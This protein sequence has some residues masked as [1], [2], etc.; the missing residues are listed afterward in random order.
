L[1]KRPGNIFC[2]PLAC[3][4]P[5]PVKLRSQCASAKRFLYQTAELLRRSRVSFLA[6]R[7]Y[8]LERERVR[9]RER[10][11]ENVFPSQVLQRWGISVRHMGLVRARVRQ[12]QKDL[13][14]GTSA[15]LDR[16]LLVYCF[17]CCVFVCVLVMRVC[18]REREREPARE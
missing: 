6:P 8:I 13:P 11:A 16:Q 17:A 5:L 1:D 14:Q 2:A 18:V 7:G 15:E 10:C 4:L 12:A 9:E 3:M